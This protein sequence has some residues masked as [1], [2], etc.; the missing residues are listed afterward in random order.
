VNV[1]EY[2]HEYDSFF[3]M[4]R[5]IWDEMETRQTSPEYVKKHLKHDPQRDT[6]VTS[7]ISYKE[8]KEQEDLENPSLKIENDE[9]DEYWSYDPRKTAT[10]DGV[11]PHRP[12]MIFE[13]IMRDMLKE[14]FGDSKYLFISFFSFS[15]IHS[16]THTLNTHTHTKH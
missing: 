7:S 9:D 3:E 2:E 1:C 5:S 16:H 14:I 6:E 15:F 10:G 12:H 8:D 11:F 4:I 13:R